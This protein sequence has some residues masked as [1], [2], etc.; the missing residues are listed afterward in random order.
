MVSIELKG[1]ITKVYGRNLFTYTLHDGNLAT[2]FLCTQ[3]FQPGES[4]NV[5]CRS[6]E[7]FGRTVLI[8]EKI[9]KCN[10]IYS[11]IEQKI[12]QNAKLFALLSDSEL[13]IMGSDFEKIARKLYAAQQLERFIVVKFHGDADGISAAL[14]LKKFLKANY[15]Q[16]NAAIYSVGDAIKDI[17]KI[18]QYFRPLLIMVDF[19]S[20]EDSSRGLALAKAGE[21]ELISIDHHPPSEFS[22]LSF[23]LS[24][25]P[26]NAG[27]EDGSKYP[28]GF[29][30]AMLANMFGIDSEGFEKIA[31]AGDKSTI[32]S[33]SNEE[34]NKALVLD[35][36]AT[37]SGFG[38]GIDF[39]LQVL[40]KNELFNSMLMQANVKLEEADR[41]LKNNIKSR[42]TQ[43]IEIFWFNLDSV[44]E[45]K[46]FPN[47]GKIT[48][49]VFDLVNS[50]KPVAVIGISKKTLIFRF[51]DIAVS[52][53]IRTDEIIKQ[54]KNNF[55]DFIEN[56][57]GHAYAAA[58][59]I[60]DPTTYSNCLLK[61]PKFQEGFENIALEEIIKIITAY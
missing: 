32:L 24:L 41:I 50:N 3:F 59:R 2:E 49:R 29:L 4:V 6:E 7:K 25:N 15:F 18:G 23:A 55:S 1:I 38:N 16:Q 21:I 27:Y 43:N 39:Y 47:K 37:Y 13:K 54:M 26:W 22:V 20:G 17:E 60:K 33:I 61:F 9:E 12:G 42:S 14:I 8:A 11:E 48:G 19:G 36:A 51:N 35:F 56:G 10:D 44:A 28:T 57:G 53:G 52:K 40:S 34:K 5:L 45:K 46:E 58:L 31:C 30:C